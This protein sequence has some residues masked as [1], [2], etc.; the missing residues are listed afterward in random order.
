MKGMYF[1][2]NSVFR[3]IA[4]CT[5]VLVIGGAVAS[6]DTYI[7]DANYT[8]AI[9]LSCDTSEITS[10][11][12]TNGVAVT[13]DG[14]LILSAGANAELTV[15]SGSQTEN[16]SVISPINFGF[17][18]S[19][20]VSEAAE[21]ENAKLNDGD[22]GKYLAGSDTE[23][24]VLDFTNTDINSGILT[25]EF[26]LFKED[27]SATDI[28]NIKSV[29]DTDVCCVMVSEKGMSY[30]NDVY[31][32]YLGT[33]GRPVR[34]RD[35]T[36]SI[37]TWYNMKFV[38]NFTTS[39][40]T[41]YMDG[42]VK[43]ADIPLIDVS[44]GIKTISFGA[45]I[46]DVVMSS[47]EIIEDFN[48]D[49]KINTTINT[50]TD[51]VI[52]I[53]PLINIEFMGEDHEIDAKYCTLSVD[54]SALVPADGKVMV[55]TSI[56]TEISVTASCIVSGIEKQCIKTI[57]ITNDENGEQYPLLDEITAYVPE[58]TDNGV[59]FAVYNPKEE[60]TFI[61]VVKDNDGKIVADILTA[62]S[63]VKSELILDTYD[64]SEETARV[65]LFDTET[66]KNL[67]AY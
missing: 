65:F 39:K 26:K 41:L 51:G 7:S 31:F 63:G 27:N 36:M 60:K 35:N 12:D 54:G 2:M 9:D 11:T 33:N 64:I 62:Q 29:Q 22:L 24:A 30:P 61:A 66:M 14:F 42:S 6:A 19:V 17:D 20:T 47:G 13:R 15:K 5:S 52:M 67:L 1:K 37:N 55:D 44:N 4:V 48:I 8:T 45:Y 57:N 34:L 43:I 3:L 21:F 10:I 50:A 28:M 18:D 23:P 40:A 53:D 38:M 58:F 56:D 46:D 59:T 32:S 25:L 16:V 49:S